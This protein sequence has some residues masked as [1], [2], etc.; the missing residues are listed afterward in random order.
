MLPN[1]LLVVTY[2]RRI[3][4]FQFP[5]KIYLFRNTVRF[6]VGYRYCQSAVDHKKYFKVGG[7][8]WHSLVLMVFRL[9]L[10]KSIL[11]HVKSTQAGSSEKPYGHLS[12]MHQFGMC[13]SIGIG[14]FF[15]IGF[16]EIWLILVGSLNVTTSLIFYDPFV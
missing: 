2:N 15:G 11:P 8:K 7:V 3:N 4:F 1:N 10:V 16:G 14:N 12:Q 6:G 5:K 13:Q 9:Q